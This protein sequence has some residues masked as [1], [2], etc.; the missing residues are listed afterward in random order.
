MFL[1]YA[2]DAWMAR[3]LPSVPFERY[4]DDIIV[5]ARSERQARQL[6]ATIARGWRSAGSSSTSKD[7]HRVL[8]G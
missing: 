7:P 8:Q 1:H 6:R 2:F 4:C 3:E 5:H